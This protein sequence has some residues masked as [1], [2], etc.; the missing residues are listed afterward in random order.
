MVKSH[1]FLEM[2]CSAAQS[3][4]TRLFFQL[5]YPAVDIAQRWPQ[6]WFICPPFAQALASCKTTWAASCA[7]Q[8]T[9]AGSWNH[10]TS[11]K[12]QLWINK[13][14]A[15]SNT[16]VT[17]YSGPHHYPLYS[18]IHLLLFRQQ[19][20]RCHELSK[21]LTHK[22]GPSESGHWWQM[23][24]GVWLLP[25]CAYVFRAIPTTKI[26]KICPVFHNLKPSICQEH[27]TENRQS[28][29]IHWSLFIEHQSGRT[30]ICPSTRGTNRDGAAWG[31]ARESGRP[32]ASLAHS[33][34]WKTYYSTKHA[35]KCT[36]KF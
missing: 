19:K 35:L 31:S 10:S 25:P 33:D 20:W 14:N 27:T 15:W 22:G 11:S 12:N 24:F 2:W 18:T 9:W 21:H 26:K 3:L 5:Q 30:C 34:T 8:T 6:T 7:A 36:Q 32:W 16:R 29:K 1:L 17:F 13:E 23:C 4:S 28:W